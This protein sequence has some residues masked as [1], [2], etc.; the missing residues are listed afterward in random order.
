MLT[1]VTYHMTGHMLDSGGHWTAGNPSAA[2]RF[3]SLEG[4]GMRQLQPWFSFEQG[5]DTLNRWLM[6]AYVL[7]VAV[8][9]SRA[10]FTLSVVGLML[11]LAPLLHGLGLLLYSR[12]GLA[13]RMSLVAHLL[14]ACLLTFA[15]RHG[16]YELLG[17]LLS[18]CSAGIMLRYAAWLAFPAVLGG[19]TVYLMV[20]EPEIQ[21]LGDYAP[22]LLAFALWAFAFYVIR[23]LIIQRQEILDLNRR[24]QS[25][26]ALTAEMIQL[27]ERNRLAEALHD[28]IGHTLT[29]AVVSLEGAA[30]LFSRRPDEATALLDSVRAQLQA[31]LGNLRQTVRNLRTEGLV[32]QLTLHESLAHL[33]ERVARQ[34][35]VR[36]ELRYE[37][38]AELLPIQ[39]YLLFTVAREGITNALKHGRPTRI[40]V[41]LAEI[42]T[43]CLSL[44]VTD[45]G[46]GASDLEPGFGLNHLQQKVAAL[47]GTMT[48]ETGAWRG[49]QL[50]ALLPLAL[51][52]TVPVVKQAA[53]E[54]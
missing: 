6:L 21:W 40:T 46:A 23:L 52:G 51:E 35:P 12:G 8:L 22:R 50:T 20:V 53:K 38:A 11:G 16:D 15:G 9:W 49:F 3:R 17:A 13:R 44:S 32:D 24:L 28:T 54:E 42:D 30:L 1:H 41:E 14:E 2:L 18:I 25:Q 7:L 5:V 26:A 39:E 33:V 29:S 37:L 43:A 19:F 34:V 4:Y 31:D 36:L 10:G 27:R 47:G 48:F 45:D